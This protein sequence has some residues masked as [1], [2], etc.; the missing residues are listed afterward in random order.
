MVLNIYVKCLRNKW[1][2]I[3]N[4]AVKVLYST[5]AILQRMGYIIFKA[6]MWNRLHLS[7]RSAGNAQQFKD[8]WNGMEDEVC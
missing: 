2:S 6:R 7:F 3:T 1:I 8:F 4:E 5:N